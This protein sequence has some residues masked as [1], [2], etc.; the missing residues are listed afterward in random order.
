M[1]PA[2]RKLSTEKQVNGKLFAQVVTTV[3]QADLA[4]FFP[5]SHHMFGTATQATQHHPARCLAPTHVLADDKCLTW[6]L[7]SKGTHHSAGLLKIPSFYKTVILPLVTKL[8]PLGVT[9]PLSLT[10]SFTSDGAI[11]MPFKELSLCELHK[12][13]R[14]QPFPNASFS[15]S[16]KT[17]FNE[18]I[19]P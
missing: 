12:Q 3:E 7:Y 6:N 9:S 17:F 1:R 5:N 19:K 15:I 2:M 11:L 8:H 14:S 16:F 13:L 10:N 4:N 18:D